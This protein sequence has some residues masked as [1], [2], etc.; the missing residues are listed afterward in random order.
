MKSGPFTF[1]CACL[2]CVPRSMASAKRLF[3]RLTIGVRTEA[4][5]SFRVSYIAAHSIFL[6]GE[7]FPRRPGRGPMSCLNGVD[8]VDL[9]RFLHTLLEATV[10]AVR[11]PVRCQ[12]ARQLRALEFDFGH[13]RLRGG[14]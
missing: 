8:R 11:V 4:G 12:G 9:W 2:A 6:Y 13:H 14:A 10:H 7:D 3:R 1:Q 5:K